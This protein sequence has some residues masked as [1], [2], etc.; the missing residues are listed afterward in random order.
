MRITV[1]EHQNSE[2]VGRYMGLLTPQPSSTMI[3]H[4]V[5]SLKSLI[6][7]IKKLTKKQNRIL[8]KT[9]IVSSLSFKLPTK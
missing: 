4:E 2:F 8:W 5:K 3:R 9:G 6:T 1:L 7:L